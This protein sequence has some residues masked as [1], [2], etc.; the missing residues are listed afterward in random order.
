MLRILAT[1][2]LLM[3]FATTA[4]ATCL[5]GPCPGSPSLSTFTIEGTAGF[6][7]AAGGIFNGENGFV[8]AMNQGYSGVDLQ[9]DASGNLCGANCR[10]G[11][12][13]VNAYAG[14]HAKVLAAAKGG[15]SGRPVSVAT[16]GVSGAFIDFRQK[17]N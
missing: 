16:E 11:E 1:G 6:S 5:S 9:M 7:G 15:H 12:F 14:H 10:S 13:D 3:G 4:S 2:A 8:K 17:K